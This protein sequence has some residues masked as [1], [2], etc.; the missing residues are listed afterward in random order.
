[1]TEIRIE[2]RR[3]LA[4]W[5]WAVGLLVLALAIWGIAELL[6]EDDGDEVVEQLEREGR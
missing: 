5:P 1:M 6:G 2:R 3:R 4:L